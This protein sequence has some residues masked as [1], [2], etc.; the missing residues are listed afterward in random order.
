M[1]NSAQVP[2]AGRSKGQDYTQQEKH[3][4]PIQVSWVQRFEIITVIR[5]IHLNNSLSVTLPEGYMVMT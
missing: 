1:I 2:D 4:E 3:I 5:L